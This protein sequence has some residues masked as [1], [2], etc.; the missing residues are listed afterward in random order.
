MVFLDPGWR[1][2]PSCGMF[3]N[4]ATP[5]AIM[6]WKNGTTSTV[7]LLGQVRKTLSILLIYI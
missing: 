4:A 5:M 7:I 2:S 3:G 6:S 1:L